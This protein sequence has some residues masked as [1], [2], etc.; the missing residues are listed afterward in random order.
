M[1]VD[2]FQKNEKCSCLGAH[3]I[4]AQE[5]ERTKARKRACTF[6]EDTGKLKINNMRKRRKRTMKRR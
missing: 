2:G 5:D 3:K 6:V 4:A 1:T